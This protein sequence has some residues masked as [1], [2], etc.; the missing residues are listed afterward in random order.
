MA[1]LA[2]LGISLLL[3][4]F[5][6]STNDTNVHCLLLHLTTVLEGLDY[7]AWHGSSEA[8]GSNQASL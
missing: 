6:A 7:A 2:N 1:R 5:S 4:R 8:H 3:L